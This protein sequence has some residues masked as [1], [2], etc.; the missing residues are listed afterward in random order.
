MNTTL[1]HLDT[2]NV[3]YYT[4]RW[5]WDL[6]SPLIPKQLTIWEAFRSNDIA[7]CDSANYLR[8]LGFN[9][10]NPLCDF[11]DTNYD[12]VKADCCV[13][14][15]PFNKK[16]EVLQRLLEFDKPFML[17]LPNIILNTIYFIEMAKKHSELQIVI[18]PK[19][20]DFIKQNK[21][22]S[23]ASFHTLVVCYK[24]NLRQRLTFL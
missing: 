6:L 20:I 18:L 21:E 12:D 15:P 11:F 3:E 8:E 24:F 22:K 16:K 14:N 23:V 13:S 19:R 4:P 1:K 2:G 9:V 10:V 5:V 7:S 17:I